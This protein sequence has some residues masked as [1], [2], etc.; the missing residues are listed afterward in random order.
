MAGRYTDTQKIY[1]QYNNIGN[2]ENQ[3]KT[4]KFIQ[5]YAPTSNQEDEE[6][7]ILYEDLTSSLRENP[8]TYTN[9]DAYPNTK[10]GKNKE[11]SI[12]YIVK[13]GLATRNYRGDLLANFENART[14]TK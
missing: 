7:E 9:I 12:Q 14:C 6:V 4:L 3:Q 5:T 13:H 11:E 10:V 2:I 8:I 1:I